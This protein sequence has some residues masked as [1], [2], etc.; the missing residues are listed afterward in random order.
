VARHRF[1]AEHIAR[2]F[3]DVGVDTIAAVGFDG[4]VARAHHAPPDLVVCEYDLLATVSLEAW[5]H[6]LIL[7]HTPVLAVSLTR[8]PNEMHPLDVNGIAGFLYLPT[9]AADDAQKLIYAA[10]MPRDPLGRTPPTSL[11]ATSADTFEEA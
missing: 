1:L 5:E 4:A 11:P 6:D 7:S 10:A 9:L 8:H 2:F 3:S